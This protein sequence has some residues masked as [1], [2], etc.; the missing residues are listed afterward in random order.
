M[1][2]LFRFLET[3][4]NEIKPKDY[5]AVYEVVMNECDNNDNS[6]DLHIYAK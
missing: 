2:P 1:V 4:V 5:T 3:G 6:K